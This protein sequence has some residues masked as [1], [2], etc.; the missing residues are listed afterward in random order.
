MADRST[1]IGSTESVA[2]VEPEAS[3]FCSP[4]SIFLDKTELAERAEPTE[5]M[6]AG[7]Y[8]ERAILNEWNKRNGWAFVFNETPHMRDDG[9][10]ATPDAVDLLNREGAE[11]KTVTPEVREHWDNGTPRYIWWQAQHEMLCADLDRIV[12]I[13]QFGFQRLAHEWIKR[14][15]EAGD[16]IVKACGEMWKRIRGELPPPEPDAHKATTEAL[17]R[18]KLEAKVIELGDDVREWSQILATAEKREKENA[19][20]IAEM[21]NK[22]RAALGDANTGIWPDGTGWRVQTITRKES[23]VKASTYTAMKRIKNK[24]AEKEWDGVSE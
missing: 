16:R 11:V 5:R 10:G 8:L 7:K 22:I 9:I 1:Y 18:R 19:A 12:V 2:L 14:D 23:V 20:V 24:D 4:M 15:R 21:K 6:N 17:R 13:A 3:P